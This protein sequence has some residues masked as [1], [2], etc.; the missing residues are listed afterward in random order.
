M[1][2]QI[3]TLALLLPAAA[4]AQTTTDEGLS[5]GARASVEASVKLA[6]GLH[7]TAHEE[8]R[9]YWG[10]EDRI[11]F[12]TGAGIEYKVLPFLKLGAEYELINRNKT[13]SGEGENPWS[14]RHR[15]NFSAAG[16]FRSG[17]WQFGLKETLRLTYRPGEMNTFQS[18]RTAL[19]LKSK[20]SVKYRRW[21]RVIPFAAFEVRN[22]LN[23]PAYSGTYHPS[24]KDEVDIY[25]D[26]TFLGYTHAYVNRLRVQA[27]VTA[28]FSKHHELDF[29]LFGD[30]YREKNIDTN[31]E[32]SNNWKANGLVLK[33]IN[34]NTGNMVSACV[35]YKWSF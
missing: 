29:Y 6:T 26:E 4:F 20:V 10:T 30:H 34:W 1:K 12:H 9:L 23:D 22:T 3:L 21:G 33:S 17:D 27:G 24:A 16:T 7:L 15:G 18:P 19:A 13:V 28:K 8:T 14:I 5:F 2:R 35:S 11:R 31:R 32:G 25:T